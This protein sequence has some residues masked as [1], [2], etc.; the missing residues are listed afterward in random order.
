VRTDLPGAPDIPALWS[1][2]SDTNRATS[3]CRGNATVST[4]E[5]LL[6]ALAGLGIDDVRIETTAEELPALD[7][8]ATEWVAALDVAGRQQHP[9]PNTPL[10]PSHSIQVGDSERSLSLSPA[11]VFSLHVQ[12][13]FEHPDVGFQEIDLS[14]DESTFRRELA[15]AR[16]F[17]FE[18]EL[19]H[20]Q[21]QNLVRGVSLENAV[22]YGEEGVLN[23]GGLRSPDEVVR[24]KALD[25]LGDLALLGRPFLGRLTARRPGH[26][27]ALALVQAL[28]ESPPA[29]LN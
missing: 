13:E 29:H 27:L 5:H 9:S 23:P 3:L 15:W 25:L 17:G 22:V 7:G 16:T 20:L 1:Q 14:L 4:V 24:H 18:Q 8:S 6:A 12:V 19:E 11:P 10:A 26:S 2:V 21:A 28:A